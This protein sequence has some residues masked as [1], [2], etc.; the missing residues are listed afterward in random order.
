MFG[1]MGAGTG[2]LGLEG[3]RGDHETPWRAPKFETLLAARGPE[4]PA[5]G[6]PERLEAV[7]SGPGLGR[8]PPAAG[9]AVEHLLPPTRKLSASWLACHGCALQPRALLGTGTL[10]IR[11]KRAV[12]WP[13]C[14]PPA[15]GRLP[16]ISP[17]LTV[18]SFH[19]Q[20]GACPQVI[21]LIRGKE[22][23][24]FSSFSILSA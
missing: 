21:L 17:G 10:R 13:G 2:E 19:W 15:A 11:G 6:R 20:Q 22:R 3:A 9:R 7:G 8:V 23:F 24:R 18:N 5:G 16:G 1:R 14:R 4:C 12:G